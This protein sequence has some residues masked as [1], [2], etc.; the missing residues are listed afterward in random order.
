M[1]AVSR[2]PCCDPPPPPLPLFSVQFVSLLHTRAH[3]H[4]QDWF[5]A[6]RSSPRPFWKGRTVLQPLPRMP[7]QTYLEHCTRRQRE[8]VPIRTRVARCNVL[9]APAGGNASRLQ[10]G[11]SLSGVL[12]RSP[13][14]TRKV[15]A[16]ATTKC[17]EASKQCR[18]CGGMEVIA[19]MNMRS[20]I[21][22][23]LVYQSHL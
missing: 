5:H 16:T 13:P 20:S 19:T 18:G 11:E 15:T 10:T 6:R 8:S 23:V 2:F 3:T 14:H 9:L 1:N 12:R 17:K 7:Q 21:T 4:T 22:T